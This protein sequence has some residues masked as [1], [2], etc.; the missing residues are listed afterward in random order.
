MLC[1]EFQDVVKIFRLKPMSL[2]KGH[3]LWNVVRL[4][5]SVLILFY[6]TS[7]L[8]LQISMASS[9]VCWFLC[10]VYLPLLS[11]VS[12]LVSWRGEVA[13]SLLIQQEEVWAGNRERDVG[14]HIY[15]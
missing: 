4:N 1:L 2:N 9:H 5:P 6:P 12:P 3:N 8:M 11:V 14:S 10:F 13:V 15:R 7:D